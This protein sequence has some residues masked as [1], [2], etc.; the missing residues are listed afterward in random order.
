MARYAVTS[1]RTCFQTPRAL[2]QTFVGRKPQGAERGCGYMYN[3]VHMPRYTR[4]KNERTCHKQ[5]TEFTTSL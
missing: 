2:V 4:Q 3:H 1:C 5:V